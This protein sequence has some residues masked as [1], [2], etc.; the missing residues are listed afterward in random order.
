M[1]RKNKS[2]TRESLFEGNAHYTALSD[3]AK[4]VFQ[5]IKKYHEY[6]KKKDK[7]YNIIIKSLKLTIL[8]LAMI[9]TIILGLK[10]ILNIE[11]QVIVGLIS[12]SLITFIS[13]VAAYFNFEEY[14]M[15]NISI[16]IELNI[17]RDNFIFDTNSDKMTFEKTSDY[18]TRLIKIQE[19]NIKY[20]KRRIQCL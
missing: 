11:Y 9:N 14:W 6:F 13:A 20:W 8:S 19:E 12:S 10:G 4:F 17:L 2:S 7:H 16:H 18:Q 1:R 3:E 15:R 5:Q